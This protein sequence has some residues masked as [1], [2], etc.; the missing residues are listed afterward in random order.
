MTLLYLKF[1]NKQIITYKIFFSIEADSAKGFS[2]SDFGGKNE[3]KST[4]SGILNKNTK[5]FIFQE[6]DLIYTKANYLEF[7]E[8]CNVHFKIDSN[9]IE[10][11]NKE[12]NVNFIG[13]FN[14]GLECASGELSLFFVENIKKKI[15]KLK[16][17]ISNKKVIKKVLGDS[18]QKSIINSLDSIHK[19]LENKQG[20][21]NKSENSLSININ[22]GDEIFLKDLGHEDG[23]EVII[24]YD[25]TND[26]IVLTKQGSKLK[27]NSSNIFGKLTLIGHKEGSRPTIPLKLIISNKGEIKTDLFLLLKKK[28][29]VNIYYQNN[30]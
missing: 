19:S 24:N 3:T 4:L 5:S 12:I 7:D 6:T 2:V 23:D 11:P 21:I 27:I 25:N 22:I 15:T 28:K 29:K 14:D 30:K 18:L 10:N 20:K 9:I 17:K 1:E 13:K 8:F 26:T 16:K